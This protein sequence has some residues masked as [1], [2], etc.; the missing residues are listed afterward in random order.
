MTALEKYVR[1]EAEA[2]WSE[3]SGAEPRSVIVSFGNATLVI[4]DISDAP[5]T[6]WSLATTRIVGREGDT[7]IYAPDD[8]GQETLHVSDPF[9]VEAI[10]EVTASA[11]KPPPPGKVRKRLPVW[12]PLVI[13]LLAI[14]LLWLPAKIR[15]WV[16]G[17]VS[18]EQAELISTEIL[19]RMDLPKCQEPR[20]SQALTNLEAL[21]LMPADPAVIIADLP[22]A[23]IAI[24]PDARTILDVS[25]L[26]DAPSADAFAGWLALA[27]N[28]PERADALDNLI[29]KADTGRALSFAFTGNL[30]EDELEQMAE[31]TT[32]STVVP[33]PKGFQAAIGR[34][35]A[36]GIAVE[37]FRSSLNLPAEDEM[38][39]FRPALD[40]QDWQALQRICDR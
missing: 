36:A 34:L 25:I 19:E 12:I 40:D 38:G 4:T 17:N 11:V 7:V 10:R 14:S 33:N 30:S 22:V 20:A 29:E 2:L 3:S 18:S 39:P 6:H 15:T 5:I 31:E 27:A 16:A 23:G 21:V 28:L 24:L 37:P 8:S 35:K 26:G 13:A 1:L 32:T 9:L